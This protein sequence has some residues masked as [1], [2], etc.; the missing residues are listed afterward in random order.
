[1][2]LLREDNERKANVID[3]HLS[4]LKEKDEEIEKLKITIAELEAAKGENL[5]TLTDEL[6]QK[7][8]IIIKLH[9]IIWK[10]KEKKQ[11]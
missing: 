11:K 1:M 8:A 7:E 3:C 9:V 5:G 4:V 10:K 2:R 6:T